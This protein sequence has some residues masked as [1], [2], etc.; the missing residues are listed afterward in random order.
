MKRTTKIVLMIGIALCALGGILYGVGRATGGMEKLNDSQ[1]EVLKNDSKRETVTLEK[2]NLGDIQRIDGSIADVDLV[3]K[4]SED[5][6]CYLSYNVET[7]KGKDP[8]TYSVKDGTLELK[9]DGGYMNSFYV[10]VDIS[11][12]SQM[13]GEKE[14]EEHENLITLYLP[15]DKTLEDC[16]LALGD[17]DMNIEKLHSKNMDLTLRSGDLAGKDIEAQTGVISLEDGDLDLSDFICWNLNLRS[18]CGDVSLS[19]TE[20]KDAAITMQDGD[21]SAKE[22]MLTGEAQIQ[23]ESGDVSISPNR[24]KSGRLAINAR[25]EW[26]DIAVESFWKGSLYDDDYDDT[27]KYERSVENPSAALNVKSED[28]DISIK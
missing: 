7:R 16:K 19:S 21:L 28:G 12:L 4:P 6:S 3:V 2:E 15:E 10:Q 11:F 26:G 23:S 5:D 22:L 17:G 1:T 8:V 13:T 20:L 27:A 18:E 25:T 24:E 14:S 9:E